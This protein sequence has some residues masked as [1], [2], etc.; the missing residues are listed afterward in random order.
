M[1]VKYTCSFIRNKKDGKIEH[2]G[3]RGEVE[4]VPDALAKKMI[5]DKQAAEVVEAE[6]ETQPAVA[7][8]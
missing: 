6:P 3:K 4:E 1:K 7:D 8:D 5:K 2:R